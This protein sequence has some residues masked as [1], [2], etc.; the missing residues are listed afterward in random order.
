M[1][2]NREMDKKQGVTM[3]YLNKTLKNLHIS[4][5]HFVALLRFF[6]NKIP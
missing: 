2:E 6:N 5:S 4:K 1:W 3:I